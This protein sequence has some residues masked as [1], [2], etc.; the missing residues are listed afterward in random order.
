VVLIIYN[1]PKKTKKVLER[2]SK[3][4]PPRMYIVADG[5]EEGNIEDIN[6]VKKTRGVINIDWDCEIITIFA[7][8]NMGLKDRIVTGLDSVFKNERRVILIEDDIILDPGGFRFLEEMA[9]KY[10]TDD[11]IMHITGY[12][13]I[14][15]WKHE[16]QDY[17]FSYYPAIW[18]S[19]IFKRVWEEYDPMMK[20]W[21]S[22]QVRNRIRDVLAD[23]KQFSER[24]RMYELAIRNQDSW[25]VPFGFTTLINSGLSVVPSKNLVTNIGFGSGATHTQKKKEDYATRYKIDF[26]IQENAFVAVDREYDRR[27]H[28][29]KGSKIYQYLLSQ[30]KELMS[31]CIGRSNG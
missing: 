26:P 21:E 9:D 18:G 2:I 30:G 13:R 12:N 28:D 19:V 15:K 24:K 4:E 7:D 25:A 8:H 22:A 6:A 23:R 1:R 17:H 29:M 31:K 20:L 10:M 11:R 14:G 5:P 16:V 3:V 27:V